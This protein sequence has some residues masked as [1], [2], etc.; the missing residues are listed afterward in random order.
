[1]LISEEI[2]LDR[3]CPNGDLVIATKLVWFAKVV[4]VCRLPTLA[5]CCC[6]MQCSLLSF[7][8]LT[9]GISGCSECRVGMLDLIQSKLCLLL[10][11]IAGPLLDF[12]CS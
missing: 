2:L 1:M 10:A 4:V 11:F 7:L 12:V 8:K 6:F 3:S 9:V 5:L